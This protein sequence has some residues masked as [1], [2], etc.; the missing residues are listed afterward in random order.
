MEDISRAW[1]RA[2]RSPL[3]PRRREAGIALVL[4]LWVI[5]LLTVMALGLTATQ[6]TETA[7]TRNQLDVVRF[8]ALTDAAI[9]YAI[10]NLQ[11]PLPLDSAD[12]AE[13][14]LPD[15]V[16]RRWTFAGQSLQVTLFN[17]KSRIDLNLAQVEA[18]QSLLVAVGTEPDTAA[19]L[20]NRILDW[21]D[22]DDLR[23]LDGAEDSDYEAE[24]WPYGAKDGPFDTVE[25]LQQVLGMNR[26]LYRQIATAL[27]TDS[28]SDKV[29]EELATPLVI[30]ALRGLT[31][32]QA[33]EERQ[34]RAEPGTAGSQ[35]ED[36]ATAPLNR[37]GP[38]YRVQVTWLVDGHPAQTSETLVISNPGAVP[39]YSIR[40][41]RVGLSNEPAMRP[42]PST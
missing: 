17:E 31:L 10:L 20:A 11:S 15:A 13:L 22:E 18:L 42:A 2:Q 4:V 9:N 41:R 30:A 39:P 3:V 36:L 29:E 23:L 21:R 16:P 7:L 40:W 33:E 12:Q 37:G 32:E 8:R 28:D 38:L 25:E 24:G 19:S 5:A 34:L 1:G 27:S 14:W 6:R 35:A 26:S